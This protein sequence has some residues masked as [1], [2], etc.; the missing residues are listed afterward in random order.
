[1]IFFL[2]YILFF[3]FVLEI[4]EMFDKGGGGLIGIGGLDVDFV[5][6]LFKALLWNL[7]PTTIVMLVIDYYKKRDK[8]TRSNFDEDESSDPSKN[9]KL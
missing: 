2:L 1:M 4:V 3:P 6:N 7:F 5:V 9:W 8:E